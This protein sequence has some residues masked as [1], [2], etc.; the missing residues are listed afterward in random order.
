MT[1]PFPLSLDRAS[2]TSLT[3]Q[4]RDGIAAA[5]GEGR[6]KP[7]ARLPS[8]RDLA[9]QLGVA[10][11]T[12]RAAYNGLVDAQLAV[13]SGSA[14]T[15]VADYAPV[16]PRP[17]AAAGA[18]ETRLAGMFDRFS[19]R[20]LPFQMGV[21][22]QD[23]F[24]FKLWSRLMARAARET[25][26][27]P[28]SYPDPRGEPELRQE[29][30]AY[31]AIAR[32]IS[33]AP[34]QIFITN[35]FSGALGFVIQA[36]ALAG[37]T[38]WMEE[39]GY[40]LSRKALELSRIDI[41]PVR[42]DHEGLDVA[43]GIRSAP[44]ARLA[45]VTPGQQAPLGTTLSLARRR[46]LLDWAAGAQSWIIEDDYLSELQLKGRATPALAAVDQA[47]R[48]IH[49]GTFSK[50]IS[51]VLRLGFIV[52]PGELVAHFG[53]V[54]AAL[55]P[56]PGPQIQRAVTLFMREGH[57]MR[58]LRRMKRLYAS[59]RD[60]LRSR[61][62]NSVASV[63]AMAGLGLLLRLPEGTDDRQIAREAQGLGMGP[64][65]LSA[66]YKEPRPTDTGLVLSVTNLPDKRLAYYCAELEK[67]IRKA[68]ASRAS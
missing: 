32:G 63:E 64:A 6:L 48:V 5:I 26:I 43:Q 20:P 62:G 36:L 21:P 41:V 4:I 58:H 54:A 29:I 12:V 16:P 68:V 23:E 3:R 39:P 45:F 61:L 25:A 35:G 1:D 24:P 8:W 13:T 49:I 27:V 30:A 18:E 11:G 59:R 7:G 9:A 53:D 56:A 57:Y 19:T 67:L 34:A 60:A 66:W 51:P 22:A 40:P 15:H 50:T 55:S 28:T 10:R 65:A 37:K 47:G 31:L 38:A 17:R 46:A 42:T 14:G 44:G 2:G 33:A 52:A